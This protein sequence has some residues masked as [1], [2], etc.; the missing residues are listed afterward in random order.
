MDQENRNKENQHI[1]HI[2]HARKCLRREAVLE[3]LE[4]RKY[5]TN[6]KIQR[7]ELGLKCRIKYHFLQFFFDLQ[8]CTMH[9]FPAHPLQRFHHQI[10]KHHHASKHG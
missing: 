1:R 3:R 9:H 2:N 10:D 8:G 4:V 6:R 7:L 5:L